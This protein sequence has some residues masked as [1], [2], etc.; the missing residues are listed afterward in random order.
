M[1]ISFE[2]DNSIT[3]LDNEIIDIKNL[4][5]LPEVYLAQRG[6]VVS[7]LSQGITIK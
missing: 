2:N 3:C 6:K 5:I 7:K 1:I 4:D